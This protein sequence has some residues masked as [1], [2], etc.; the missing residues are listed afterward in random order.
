MI[1]LLS[2]IYVDLNELVIRRIP[3]DKEILSTRIIKE[4]TKICEYFFNNYYDCETNQIKKVS[5]FLETLTNYI[6][7][8]N[9]CMMLT[10]NNCSLNNIDKTNLSRAFALKTNIDIKSIDELSELIN[11]ELQIYIENLL[12]DDL[13]I[14]NLKSMFN[15]YVFSECKSTIKSINGQTYNFPLKLLFKLY[16]QNSLCKDTN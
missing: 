10:S 4:H 5:C 6:N 9:L 2:K 14:D 1:D 3:H 15:K 11:K 16:G 12:N 7:N 13:D 8:Y